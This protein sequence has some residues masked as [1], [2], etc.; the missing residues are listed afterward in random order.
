ACI[1]MIVQTEAFMA[2][3]ADEIKSLVE[4][5]YTHDRV[6]VHG[7]SWD[8]YEAVLEEVGNRPIRVTYDGGEL[9]IMAPPREHEDDTYS[10]GDLVRILLEEL[11]LN[12]RAQGSR[13]W[14]RK[15]L[16]SGLEADLCYF[17]QNY[18]RVPRRTSIEL[19]ADP[20]PDLAIEIDVS[21]S[22]LKK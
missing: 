17:I 7:V 11:R 4:R 19:P 16:G 14:R 20:A 10:I 5:V 21:R 8:D 15:D 12:A 9:E 3:V 22:S 1:I 18:H 6:L 2:I 13:T